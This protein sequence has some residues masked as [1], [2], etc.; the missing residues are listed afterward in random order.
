MKRSFFILSAVGSLVASAH[1]QSTVTIY[2]VA[3]TGIERVTNVGVVGSVTRMPGLTGLVPSRFGFRG[4]EDLGG[5]LKAVFTLENGFNLDDG[6]TG[7]GGRMFGRQAYVGVSG[8]WGAITVGRQYTMNFWALG[9][10]DIIGPSAHG[11]G[12]IDSY[13]PNARVDNSIAY[14]GT[15][16]GL[17]VGTTYSFGRD[18]VNASSPAGTNCAGE[19]AAD[20]RAC[21]EWSGMLK[22]DTPTWGVAGSID[23]LNG[24]PGAFAGLIRSDLTD[25]RKQ[26]S[27][28]VKLGSIKLGGGIVQRENEGSALFPKSNL[29]HMGVSWTVNPTLQL[30]AALHNIRFSNT[31]NK[32]NRATV[33][34]I[35]SLSKRTALY[36][37]YSHIDNSGTLSLPVSAGA[38]GSNP[39]PGG[40]QSGMMVGIR[41]SF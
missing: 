2:G 5:G 22:Y 16:S 33:R 28:Y 18:T 1:A 19:S 10:A 23:R 7:Q 3:D 26:L 25:T 32:A 4:V 29:V 27:G 17:T 20:S 30:D 6:T 15:F 24:G 37:S 36:A 21:R 40:D 31:A 14:R 38:P 34:G 12:A 8:P 35:Y 11:L 9:E 39:V 41:H 13:I